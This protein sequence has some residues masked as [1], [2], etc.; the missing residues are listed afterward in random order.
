MS[1]TARIDEGAPVER[2]DDVKPSLPRDL[3]L[4]NA[5][6]SLAGLFVVPRAIVEG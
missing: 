4:Q 6:D 5:P 3:A 1:P 2:M